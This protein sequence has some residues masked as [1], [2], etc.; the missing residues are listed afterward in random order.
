MDVFVRQ[1]KFIDDLE[2]GMFQ[3]FQRTIE[4]F[5]YV[6]VDFIVNKQLFQR[7][8]DGEGKKLAGYARTTI[9]IKLRKGQPVDRTTL[10]DEEEFH[11]SITIDAFSDRFEVTSDVVYDKWII[12]RYGRNVLKITD[13]YMNEFMRNYFIPNL[14]SYV[15]NK[16][17]K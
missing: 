8:I 11:R 17:A 4:S 2:K 10:R 13:N 14:R 12:K 1:K 7:G 15:N 16:L 6:L 5:D 3:S 9:R